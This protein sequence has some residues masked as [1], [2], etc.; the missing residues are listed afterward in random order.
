MIIRNE[1]GVVIG[2]VNENTVILRE[3]YII[4]KSEV[5]IGKSDSIRIVIEAEREVN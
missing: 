5:V 3:E 2:I 1:Y 4:K